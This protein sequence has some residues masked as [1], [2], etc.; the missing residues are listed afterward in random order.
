MWPGLSAA[1]GKWPL[2]G[3]APIIQ[4][5]IVTRAAGMVLNLVDPM[6]VKTRLECGLLFFEGVDSSLDY[7]IKRCSLRINEIVLDLNY[8][9]WP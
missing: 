3:C 4:H 7:P 2:E 9:G 6:H 8:P 5:E 1:V